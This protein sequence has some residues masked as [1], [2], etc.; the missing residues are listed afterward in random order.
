[1]SSF[2]AFVDA[3]AT[4]VGRGSAP[5]VDESFSAD[6]LEKLLIVVWLDER[7]ADLD[8]RQLAEIDTWGDLYFLA[9][10]SVTIGG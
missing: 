5:G 1:V 8:E 4:H 3:I 2:E 7:G 6:S 10:Q 9:H